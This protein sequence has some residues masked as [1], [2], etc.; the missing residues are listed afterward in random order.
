MRIRYNYILLILLLVVNINRVLAQANEI[1]QTDSKAHYVEFFNTVDDEPIK[2]SIPNIECWDWM[3]SN[4]PFFECP[5]KEIEEIYYYRWWVFR[6]HIR[7]TQDGYVITEFLP[8][9]GHSQKHNTIA[10][11]AGLHIDE[12]KWLHNRS[13]IGDYLRFWLSG[14]PDAHHYSDWFALSTYEYCETIGDFSLA[15]EVFSA[16]VDHYRKWEELKLHESGLFWSHDGNDGGEHSISKGGLRPT[17]NSYMYA[18]ALCISKLA[19][20]FGQNDIAMEF[21]QKAENLKSLVQTNLWDEENKF[22]YN[23]PLN[24]DKKT[25]RVDNIDHTNIDPN[26]YVREL[27]GL[28][29][30]RFNLPDNGYENAWKQILDENGFYAPYGPTTAEQRHPLFMKN[31][32]KRCQWDGSSWPFSTSIALGSMR[33]LLHDYDQNVIRKKDFLNLMKIYT[34]SQHRTLP[35]GEVIPWIGESLHPHSGIWLSRAI[36]LEM[37]I[38]LVTG[39]KRIKIVLL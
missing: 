4:I 7:E 16:L 24:I 39:E 13:Y 8:N 20:R 9:V 21:Q 37:K 26:R 36:A 28:F 38:P 2:N 5:D 19:K 31:R 15:E 34:H 27:Y 3:K 14:E 32:I 33:N 35:Y 11:A 10:C 6:K 23:I 18:S 22:F 25:T 1:I 12:G 30:W 29:P 17:R